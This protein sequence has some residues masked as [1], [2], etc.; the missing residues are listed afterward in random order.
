MTTRTWYDDRL[1][2]T[3]EDYVKGEPPIES[4]IVPHSVTSLQHEVVTD[5]V[6]RVRSGKVDDAVDVLVEYLY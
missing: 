2:L 1:P 4:S 3:P 6:C 5:H